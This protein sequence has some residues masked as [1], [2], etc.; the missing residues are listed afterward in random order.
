MFDF[1]FIDAVSLEIVIVVEVFALNVLLYGSGDV[2]VDVLYY[3][4]LQLGLKRR[5]FWTC[6]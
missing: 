4:P 6:T 5:G 2:S 1:R 3:D